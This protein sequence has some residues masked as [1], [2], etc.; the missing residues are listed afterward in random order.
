MI[1][2]PNAVIPGTQAKAQLMFW[3]DIGRIYATPG[4]AFKLWYD[5]RIVGF[6]TVSP[7]DQ[8]VGS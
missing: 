6:G 3:N 5:G 4:V 1:S 7:Y 8:E 2:G